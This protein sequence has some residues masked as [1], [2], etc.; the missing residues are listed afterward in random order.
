M[1]DEAGTIAATVD[2]GSAADEPVLTPGSTTAESQTA[3]PAVSGESAGAKPD[4]TS[5]DSGILDPGKQEESTNENTG[6]PEAYEAFTMPEGFSLDDEGTRQL[7]ELFRSLNLSQRGGQKLIEA[8]AERV[9]ANKAAELEALAEQ[10]RKWRGELRKSPTFDTDRA[11]ALKGLR[12][13]AKTPEEREL[14]TNSWLSDHPA[15]FNMFVRVGRLLG[16]DVP[17]PGGG[18]A[19]AEDSATRRFPGK[20]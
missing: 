16:E 2:T 9:K 19:P 4:G 10:R 11:L 3:T 1:A 18:Q 7:G 6:A 14:F 8:Y 5:E 15:L 12:A 20:L 17:L 13:V